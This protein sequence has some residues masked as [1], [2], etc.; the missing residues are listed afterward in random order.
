M[1][2]PGHGAAAYLAQRLLK[3]ERQAT[4]A[5]CMFPDLV[6]KPVRWLLRRTPNDR[7]PAHTALVCAATTLG[8]LRW[9]GP[10]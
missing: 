1:S 4:C 9:R 8:V 2:L 7:I 10:R 5:A 6:D 3:T